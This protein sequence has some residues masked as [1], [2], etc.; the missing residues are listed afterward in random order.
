MDRSNAALKDEAAKCIRCGVCKIHCPVYN[1]LKTEPT[2]ARGKVRLI[3]ELSDGTLEPTPYFNELMSLCLNCGACSANCPPG[4]KTDEMILAVRAHIKDKNGLPAMYAGVLKGL[5]PHPALQALAVKLAYVYQHSGLQDI[6]RAS[7]FMQLLSE[8]LTKKEMLIPAVPGR[9]FRKVLETLQLKQGKSPRVLYFIS[10]M[11]NMVNVDLGTATVKVLEEHG[12]T[13]I[14]PPE[15]KCCGTPHASYGDQDSAQ[16]V[17]AHNVRVMLACH[18][19]Y[20]VTD[21]ATCGTQLK[22]YSKLV[23]EA[24]SFDTKVYDI[25]EFLVKI[26]GLKVGSQ[27]INAVVTYHDPCHLGR[28]QKVRDEPRQILTKIPGLTYK[29]M[30]NPDRC[31]GGAGTFNL[32]HYEVSM[33]ILERKIADIQQTGAELVA[34]SCPACRMQLEHGIAKAGMNLKVIHPVE[35]LAKTFI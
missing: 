23:P 11:T 3:H 34:T 4:V 30:A 28:G 19:D 35:I 32:R 25:N 1:A 14:V 15:V 18:P 20:I 26:A 22:N 13:V 10:C 12:C 31:C 7:G 17:A 33:K 29:E 9:T 5:L 24:E 2:V 16:A 27:S 8:N 6:L 21:C